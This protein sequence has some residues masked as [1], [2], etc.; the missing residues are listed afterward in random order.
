MSDRLRVKKADKVGDRIF[1]EGNSAAGWARSM[2]APPSCAW[3]PITPSSSLADAFGAHCKKLRHDPATGKAKYAIV[4]GE[5]ELAS[6][7]IVI[8]ASWN[9]ARAFHA[10]SGPG[11]SLMTDSSAVVF[12]RDPGVI[13]NVQRA[14]PRPACRRAPAC[15]IIAAPM[16]RTATPSTSCC[17]RRP[18]GSVSNSERNRSIS[19]NGCRP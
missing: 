19:P 2:A 5:D 18:G 7:G 14:G 6:I 17:S 4:Q 15:D 12:R 10:T 8:G 3:Y 11:I 16:L 1:I 9:G 13:M